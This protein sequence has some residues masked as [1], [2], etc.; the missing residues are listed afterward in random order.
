MEKQILPHKDEDGIVR[1]RDVYQGPKGDGYIDYEYRYTEGK[2]EYKGVH[3]GPESRSVPKDWTEI[4]DYVTTER[5]Q[6]G[7]KEE[8]IDE[9]V[10]IVD[11]DD[12]GSP[13]AS[14]TTQ[15]VERKTV[16]VP[17]YSDVEVTRKHPYKERFYNVSQ[18]I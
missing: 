11:E 15:T 7:V 16:Q 14:N 5:Q 6:T 9:V 4:A 10:T 1:Q 3:V 12:P 13:T 2:L 17:V 8:Q 18:S